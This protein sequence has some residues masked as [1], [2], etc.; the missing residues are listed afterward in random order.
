M[1]GVLKANTNNTVANPMPKM[2]TVPP[3]RLVRGPD[4]SGNNA[5]IWRCAIPG[6]YFFQDDAASCEGQ[7][8]IMAHYNGHASTMLERIELVGEAA[9]AGSSTAA[10]V[11]KLEQEARQWREA[12][13][14][15]SLI[16]G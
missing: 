8:A 9:V 3:I 6:C 15:D 14:R 4:T 1:P 2:Y 11:R 13:K 5:G 10:L 16:L 7:E 12:M